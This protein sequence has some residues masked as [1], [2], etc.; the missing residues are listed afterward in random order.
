MTK[1]LLSVPFHPDEVLMSFLAR[2]ARANGSPHLPRFFADL[3]IDGPGVFSGSLPAMAKLGNLIGWSPEDLLSRHPCSRGDGRVSFCGSAFDRNSV[4]RSTFRYCR[5]CL[6]HD[7]QQEDRMPCTRTY[8]R[9]SWIVPAMYVCERHSMRF[10]SPHPPKR[11]RWPAP[12]FSLMLD[13]CSN[14]GKEAGT[15]HSTPFETYV[16]DSLAG[17]C[18]HGDVLDTLPLPSGITLCTLVGMSATFGREYMMRMDPEVER[19]VRAAGYS[20]LKSGEDGLRRHLELLAGGERVSSGAGLFGRIARDVSFMDRNREFARVR[21]LMDEIA[22]SRGISPRAP[23]KIGARLSSLGHLAQSCGHPL[24]V[25]RKLLAE[26][27]M[28]PTRVKEIEDRVPPDVAARIRKVL[29]DG[30]GM[31]DLAV[32]TGWPIADCRLLADAGVLQSP[33]LEAVSSEDRPLYSLRLAASLAEMSSA[34]GEVEES[35]LVSLRDAV[36]SLPVRQARMVLRAVFAE[37]TIE[38]RRSVPGALLAGTFVAEADFV[39]LTG[40][41]K[42]PAGPE[43]GASDPNAGRYPTPRIS[44]K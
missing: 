23:S 26:L 12:D 24:W 4:L 43:F 10:D 42:S 7:E 15:E 35:G 31:T 8:V 27:G 33:M 32:R 37:R 41:G 40:H 17:K 21:S 9:T 1:G 36:A 19:Q 38:I 30:L 16:S 34:A 18:G 2:T 13:M 11:S 44:E 29:H 6:E 28:L 14:R 39:S 20:I 25:A 3:G 22:F 5:R